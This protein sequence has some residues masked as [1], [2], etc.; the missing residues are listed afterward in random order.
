MR[1]LLIIASTVVLVAIAAAG[2]VWGYVFYSTKQQVQQFISAAQP[3]ATISQRGIQVLPSGVVRVRDIKIIPHTLSD[4]ISIDA[5]EWHAPNIFALLNLRS[6][7]SQGQLPASL[8]LTVRGVNLP[9]HGGIIGAKPAPHYQALPLENLSALGCGALTYFAGEQWQAMGYER[10]ISD[11]TIGYRLF[12]ERIAINI[13]SA[14]RDWATFS[15]DVDLAL[16]TPVTTFTQLA[17]AITTKLAGLTLVMQD[18]GYNQHRNNFCATQA[19][20]DVNTYLATHVRLVVERLRQHGI[21]LGPGLVEVYQRYLSE[22]GMLTLTMRPPMP[23]QPPELLDYSAADAMKLAGLSLQFNDQPVSDLSMDWN[24]AQISQALG[25]GAT[26]PPPVPEVAPPPAAPKPAV[27][28]R[29][30]FQNIHLADLD[31]HLGQIAKLKTTS[32]V[33]YQGK[34]ESLGEGILRITIRKSGGQAT[35]SLRV[36]EIAEVQVFE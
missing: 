26:R 22:N 29:K 32:G 3:L 21:H 15:L 7:L 10:F 36:E 28:P 2:G 13:S 14:T 20:S 19:G 9:L 25:L 4:V 34:L 18:D 5:I 12:P 11:M 33:T 23:I 6:R 35:L 17:S 24:L 16:D 1:K 31:Q 30:D 8:A 27:L